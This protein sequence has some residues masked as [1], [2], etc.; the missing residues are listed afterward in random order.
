MG[1]PCDRCQ[2]YLSCSSRLACVA[3]LWWFSAR[4]RDVQETITEIAESVEWC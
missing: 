4:W 3:W 1:N 2:R